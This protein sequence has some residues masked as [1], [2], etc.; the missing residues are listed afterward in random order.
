[1]F[2]LKDYNLR[3]AAAKEEIKL[4]WA[5]A[6]AA[7]RW[8]TTSA[9]TVAG[10]L[11]ALRCRSRSSPR[12]TRTF[13]RP[14]A[15][16]RQE[17]ER[18]SYPEAKRARDN[19]GSTYRR[20]FVRRLTKDARRLSRPPIATLEQV[21]TKWENIS[22]VNAC[23][24]EIQNQLKIA[25]SRMIVPTV[26]KD[27]SVLIQVSPTTAKKHGAPIIMRGDLA[28]ISP[29]REP[30]HGTHMSCRTDW[31]GNK[32]RHVRAIHRNCVRSFALIDDQ[33]RRTAHYVLHNTRRTITLPDGYHWAVDLI[34]LKACRD[35]SLDADFH[36]EALHLMDVNASTYIAYQLELNREVRLRTK[37]ENAA[38]AA[39][40]E[41]V[42]VCLADSLKAGNC[43]AGSLEFARRHQLDPRRHYT[44]PELLAQ[45]NGDSGRVRL[46]VTAASLRHRREMERGYAVLEDHYAGADWELIQTITASTP[47][48][49]VPDIVTS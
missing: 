5:K 7:R 26:H 19:P 34:G 18:T 21:I 22:A 17:A 46:A 24:S 27:R 33:D 25:G 29:C 32:P 20:A 35:D 13:L 14:E 41:G 36:P 10:L 38:L 1:M 30:S 42:F 23:L 37:A 47:G 6:I 11:L 48:Q 49:R 43:R 40:Q 39:Q 2:E 9:K 4:R 45:A 31:I 28:E 15:W 12:Q 8:L 3:G 44:A 16:R